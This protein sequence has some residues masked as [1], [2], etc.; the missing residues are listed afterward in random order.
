MTITMANADPAV[1]AMRRSITTP[2][3][4]MILS[5]HTDSSIGAWSLDMHCDHDLILL[6]EITA[7][8]YIKVKA[9]ASQNL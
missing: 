2:L 8:T 7:T 9:N 1:D 4:W 6:N 5:N 3:L